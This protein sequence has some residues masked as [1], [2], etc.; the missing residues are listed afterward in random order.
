M[1]KG[2][3]RQKLLSEKRVAKKHRMENPGAESNYAKKA[4]FL[5][6]YGGFGFDYS[7]PKPWK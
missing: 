2:K 5:A 7:E 3:K 4:R 1:A 6:K